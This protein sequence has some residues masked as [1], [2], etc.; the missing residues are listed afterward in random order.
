MEKTL[1]KPP[2]KQPSGVRE[3][4]DFISYPEMYEGE[5]QDNFDSRKNLTEAFEKELVRQGLTIDDLVM[6][7]LGINKPT[8]ASPLLNSLIGRL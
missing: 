7:E 6:A 1:K 5:E 4:Y 2:T 8:A 3:Y